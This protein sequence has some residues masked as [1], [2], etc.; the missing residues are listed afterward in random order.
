VNWPDRIREQ[1][2]AWKARRRRLT[3]RQAW[4]SAMMLAGLVTLVY[5]LSQYGTMAWRQ[6]ELARRWQDSYTAQQVGGLASAA[7]VHDDGLVRLSIPK[8]DLDDIVVEGTSYKDLLVGP[9]HI[10]QTAEPGTVGNAVISAH[11]DTFFRHIYELNKGDEILVRRRG[12]LFRY[13][14][15]GKK[16]TD[17]DDVAVLKPTNDAQLTL[18]TCYP[19]YYIG[20]APERLVVFS[21]L[22]DH[23][24]DT[25]NN[26]ADSKPPAVTPGASE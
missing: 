24:P 16:I 14:V 19:T 25:G 9:G 3:W 2:P 26:S 21:K 17:P 12:Q 8:I 23:G 11:R 15:T 18:I 7:P 6:H 4:P 20:P 22:A 13:Q 10:E 5:V 1:V